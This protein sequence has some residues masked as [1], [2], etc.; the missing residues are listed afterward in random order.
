MVSIPPA[1]TSGG[2]LTVPSFQQIT[3][4]KRTVV[5]TNVNTPVPMAMLLQLT[6]AYA[7]AYALGTANG[8]RRVSVVLHTLRSADCGGPL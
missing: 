3:N 2:W 8:G 6:V 1:Y 5:D 4:H 7:Y